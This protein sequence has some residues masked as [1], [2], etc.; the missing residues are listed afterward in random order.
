MP[1]ALT[2]CPVIPVS[3]RGSECVMKQLYRVCK[4]WLLL[5]VAARTA[6]GSG[7]RP[8]NLPPCEHSGKLGALGVASQGL[9]RRLSLA[10][11]DVEQC[12]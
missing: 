7:S 1:T 3:Y 2:V 9:A 8:S 12:T 4:A 6:P 11:L 5:M 10:C